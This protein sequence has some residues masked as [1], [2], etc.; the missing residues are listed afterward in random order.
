MLI[1]NFPAAHSG[2]NGQF[3]AAGIEASLS[4]NGVFYPIFSKPLASPKK[5]WKVQSGNDIITNARKKK[6]G[7]QMHEVSINLKLYTAYGSN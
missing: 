5:S 4:K 1:S 3:C 6:V 7:M 2:R